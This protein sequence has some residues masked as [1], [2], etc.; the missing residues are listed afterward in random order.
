MK[1]QAD[2]KRL[3]EGRAA[4]MP[5]VREAIAEQEAGASASSAARR[6][7]RGTRATRARDKAT[8]SPRSKSQTPDA[9]PR[10]ASPPVPE[11]SDGA[12]QAASTETEIAFQQLE[13]G[14]LF[15]RTAGTCWVANAQEVAFAGPIDRVHADRIRSAVAQH[16]ARAREPAASEPRRPRGRPRKD[17]QPPAA[18]AEPKRRAAARASEKPRRQTTRTRKTRAAK[19]TPEKKEDAP[20]PKPPKAPAATRKQAAPAAALDWATI[21]GK[22]RGVAAHGAFVI[23]PEGQQ[24]GLYFT[25]PG[26]ES[27]H[28]RS[29]TQPE[30]H[31]AAEELAARG[32]PAPRESTTTEQDEALMRLFAAGSMEDER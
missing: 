20:V 13:D 24:F 32:E 28:L 16:F 14:C 11:A 12:P 9:A 4:T 17:A 21:D 1:R 7:T 27:R 25:S 30:L 29:G 31:R 6:M 2:A 8:S 5:E 26:G 3:L 18:P 15:G 10:P 23:E 22:L 19:A